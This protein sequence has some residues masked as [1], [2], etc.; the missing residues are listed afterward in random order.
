[1]TTSALVLTLFIAWTLLLLVEQIRGRRKLFS[2]EFSAPLGR[3]AASGSR[4]P[5]SEITGSEPL[6]F[7]PTGSSH[8]K[9][10]DS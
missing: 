5:T 10:P 1:M 7:Q 3:F 2:R 8:L 6:I 9:F 4:Q